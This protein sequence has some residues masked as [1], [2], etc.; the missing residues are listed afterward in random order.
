M[1]VDAFPD[2]TFIQWLDETVMFFNSPLIDMKQTASE[3]EKLVSEIKSTLPNLDKNK[4]LQQFKIIQD[5]IYVEFSKKG[6]YESKIAKK[7]ITQFRKAKRNYPQEAENAFSTSGSYER[8][9]QR[10]NNYANVNTLEVSILREPKKLESDE[11]EKEL[12]FVGLSYVYASMVGGIFRFTLQDVYRWEKVSNGEN[13]DP[14]IVTDMDVEQIQNYYKTKND[15]LYFEGY[16]PIVRH[17]VAHSNFE[18][19][20]AVKKITYV[21]EKRVLQSD[22][23]NPLRRFVSTYSFEDLHEMYNKIKSLYHLNII[24]NRMLLIETALAQLTQRHSSSDSIKTV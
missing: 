23:T 13:V 3:S 12:K 7:L 2:E 19:D 1:S 4:I 16:D 10:K 20:K 5:T 21:N 17:A 6:N 11:K 24:L 14:E 9:N 8:I 15:L 22:G 18:Y